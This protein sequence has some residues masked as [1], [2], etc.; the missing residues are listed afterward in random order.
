ERQAAR[1]ADLVIAVSELD[2]QGYV[3]RHG[4][5]PSKVIV[6]PNGAD[7]GRY[8]PV[9]AGRR[10]ALRRKLGLE[11]D[12]QVFVYTAGVPNAPRKVGLEWVRRVARKLPEFLFLVVGPLFSKPAREGNL[13]AT[14]VVD[15]PLDCLQASDYSVCP[16]QHGGGTKIKVFEA[17]AVGLPTVAFQEGIAGTRLRHEE[18][19]LLAGETEAELMS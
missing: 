17:L 12:R 19:V 9:D 6:I 8:V 11:E 18:H 4:A 15:D 7:T 13:V 3:E 14:G 1:Q 10:R 16:V 2:A 5:G